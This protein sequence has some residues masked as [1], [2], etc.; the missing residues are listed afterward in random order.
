MDSREIEQY[1]D[2]L[3]R[4]AAE[5]RELVRA[6]RGADD[7]VALDQTRQGRLS[8]ID[9]LQ[10]QQMAR[11]TMRRRAHQLARI[12]GAL[13]RIGNGDF[14]ECFV[15][16]EAIEPRRL[17]ADPASTRCTGCMDAGT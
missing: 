2:R 12:E 4:L 8:R 17:A 5:L 7:T 10:A 3:E 14:G 16:G 15:C 9:A 11:E 6:S 1:R 13:R